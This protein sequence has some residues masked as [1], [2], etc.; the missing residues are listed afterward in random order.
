MS[1]PQPATPSGDS[2]KGFAYALAA[3]VIWGILPFFFRELSHLPTLEVLAHRMIWAVPFALIVLVWMGRTQDLKAALVSPRMLTMGALTAALVSINW[4]VYVYAIQ[5]GQALDAALGYYINPLLSVFLGWMFLGEKLDR[6]QWLAVAFAVA[7]VGV[8]TYEAGRIPVIAVVLP[9]SW[10]FYAY[11]KKSLPIG[12]N[13]GF[14]L[15]VLI[16]LPFATAFVVWMELQG[17]AT[18]GHTGW[19]DVLWYLA[20]G[21]ITAVPLMIYANG[22]KLLRLTTIGI[23]QYVT[24]TMIF[25]SAVFWFGEDFGGARAI[26]FPMI[27]IALALYSFAM[28][29]NAR[30]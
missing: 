29:R 25:L 4:G 10:G 13:Q 30:R 24:P 16:L 2:P 22:A 19:R 20:C 9:L 11:F 12:P 3:Y 21:F 14:A 27:W 15:E 17:K 5:S 6:L 23:M 8:M 7:A 1:A 28:I 18:F 26:A